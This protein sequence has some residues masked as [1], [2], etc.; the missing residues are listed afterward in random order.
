MA[1]FYLPQKSMSIR[2]D[3]RFPFA[4]LFLFEEISICK[5][6]ANKLNGLTRIGVYL[7]HN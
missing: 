4:L 3:N 6:V 7:S 2:N 5:K 1:Q